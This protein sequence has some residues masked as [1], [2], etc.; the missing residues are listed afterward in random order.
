MEVETLIS[1]VDGVP[2]RRNGRIFVRHM[3]VTSC[4]G[5]S[6]ANSAQAIAWVPEKNWQPVRKK[7]WSLGAHQ[8][9]GAQLQNVGKEGGGN[10]L[11]AHD[12]GLGTDDL[13]K[14][15]VERLP[16]A[17][18]VV[19]VPRRPTEVLQFTCYY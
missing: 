4:P 18:V 5:R 10:Y 14:D 1:S 3:S 7:R 11:G 13:G 8:S 12:G 9:C 15:G 16:A 6:S 17:S 2:S 19:A